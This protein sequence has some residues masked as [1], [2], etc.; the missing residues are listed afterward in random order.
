[1]FHL[2]VSRQNKN[3]FARFTAYSMKVYFLSTP[4][5]GLNQSWQDI[6]AS[7]N[8]NRDETAAVKIMGSIDCLQ[9]A[10]ASTRFI[11]S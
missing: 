4:Y 9:D 10:L 8:T 1:M 6:Q 11:L 5:E 3:H 7:T 2:Y